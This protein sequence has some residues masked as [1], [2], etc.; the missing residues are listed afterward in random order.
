MQNPRLEPE[1]LL[2]HAHLERGRGSVAGPVNSLPILPLDVARQPIRSG[3]GAPRGLERHDRVAPRGV[4][5]RLRLAEDNDLHLDAYRFDTLD[6]FYDI[7][8]P[9]AIPEAAYIRF[10]N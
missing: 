3:A 6:F 7:S 10:D 9:V 2:A 5:E 1:L 8:A 4:H